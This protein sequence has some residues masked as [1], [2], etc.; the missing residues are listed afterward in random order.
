MAELPELSPIVRRKLAIQ[1]AELLEHYRLSADDIKRYSSASESDRRL[2]VSTTYL[3]RSNALIATGVIPSVE[4][5]K[6]LFAGLADEHFLIWEVDGTDNETFAARLVIVKDNVLAKIAARWKAASLA[7]FD[8]FETACAPA[9][10]A[11][12]NDLVRQQVSRAR[13]A[14]LVR[15]AAAKSA[16]K[17]GSVISTTL[18]AVP[19]GSDDLNTEALHV[20]R[21]ARAI[22]RGWTGAE[23]TMLSTAD[24]PNPTKE[25]LQR[26]ADAESRLDSNIYAHGQM[27]SIS[28][29]DPLPDAP[30]ERLKM[31]EEFRKL[32][33]DIRDYAVDVLRVLAEG[34]RPFESAEL[35]NSQIEGRAAEILAWA[36]GKV[37]ARDLELLDITAIEKAVDDEVCRQFSKG[38]RAAPPKWLAGRLAAEGAPERAVSKQDEPPS[39]HLAVSSAGNTTVLEV[40]DPPRDLRDRADKATARQAIVLPILQ[41]KRW[42]RSKWASEAGISKNCVYEYLDGKRDPSFQNRRAMAEVLGMKIES[43]PQ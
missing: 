37:N 27:R 14:E 9:A 36:L 20:V 21:R 11:A 40:G 32:A 13:Q 17:N 4:V 35:L 39:S 8:W 5:A 6:N 12:L 10:K 19:Y 43:L 15:L 3:V 42:K 18:L 31:A 23:G 41:A 38:T 2:A 26:I 1:E 34:S 22:I 28:N 25:Q 7:A 33:R 30:L 16:D 24:Q 29:W